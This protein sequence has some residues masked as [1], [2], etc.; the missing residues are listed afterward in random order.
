MA[1][2]PLADWFDLTQPISRGKRRWC[3]ARLACWANKGESRPT[4]P[5][6]HAAITSMHLAAKE[7]NKRLQALLDAHGDAGR[8]DG[9]HRFLDL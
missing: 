9:L 5:E 8:C 2:F 6:L 4:S 7:H 1:E 3:A